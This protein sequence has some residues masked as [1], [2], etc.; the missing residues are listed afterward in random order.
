MRRLMIACATA[1]LLA[2][3]AQSG[4]P[5]PGEQTSAIFDCRDIGSRAEIRRLDSERIEIHIDNSTAVLSQLPAASG[6][7]YA[8]RTGLWGSG[9]EW[10]QKGDMAV[11]SYTGL[12]GNQTEVVC[13]R[14]R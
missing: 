1:A 14:V 8:G 4:T 13:H 12:H 7:R 2:A 9:G 6:E 10:H 11:F 3:C 5:V